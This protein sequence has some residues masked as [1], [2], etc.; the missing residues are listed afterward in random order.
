MSDNDTGKIELAGVKTRRQW[1]YNNDTGEL[2]TKE[3]MFD[4]NTINPEAAL[5]LKLYGCKQYLADCIAN[6]GGEEFSDEERAGTMQERFANLCDDKFIIV[7]TESGFY[8]KDPNAVTKRGG[9]VVV[10]KIYA[11]CIDDGKTDAEAKAFVLKVTG[12]VYND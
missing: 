8:F 10:K 11:G 7:N 9:G 4:L 3:K 5:F 12:K 1:L 6:K 2:S